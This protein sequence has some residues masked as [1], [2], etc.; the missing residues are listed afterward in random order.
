MPDRIQRRR[1]K[2]WRKTEG[3]VIVDRQT[4]WGN[5]WQAGDP[6][7]FWWPSVRVWIDAR[8][9][10]ASLSAADVVAIHRRWLVDNDP[11]LPPMVTEY[12]QGRV[13]GALEM[14]RALI[15]SRLPELRG[16]D[17][18]CP[19]KIGQPCHAHVLLELSNA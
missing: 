7:V 14:R 3:A 12:G 11:A 17:L 9:M 8:P 16:R 4:I 6:G 1:V 2:G 5:P 15:L 18:C 13:I 10:L 19:C